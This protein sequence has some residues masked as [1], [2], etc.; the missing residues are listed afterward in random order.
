MRPDKQTRIDIAKA[1][2]VASFDIT[3]N[4]MN[5]VA[6]DAMVEDLAPY[7]VAPVMDALTRCRRECKGRLTLA[8]I[9]ERMESADGRPAADEAWMNALI[10]QDESATVIWTE[11]T[12]QA[13]AI[14]RP[15]LEIHDKTGARMAFKAAYDR[16]V[17]DARAQNRP[18]K[19]SASLGFDHEQRRAA[20]ENAVQAGKLL[21]VHAQG[22]LPPPAADER[23]AK[24]VLQIA[25]VN[26]ETVVPE[27]ARREIARRKI[28]EL[29]AMLDGKR[30]A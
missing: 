13:F 25:C 2:A 30:S 11:E 7:G 22:L 3:G 24:A 27:I 21:P 4:E 14:A 15:A 20:L 10:A 26:G 17:S 5:A 16:L 6:L 19:W 8:D 23:I 1:L 9:L 12:Q 18:A 29:K 28:A